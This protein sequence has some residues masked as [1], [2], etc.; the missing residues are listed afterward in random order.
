MWISGTRRRYQD[1][2]VSGA[3]WRIYGLC[4]ALAI[5]RMVF[6]QSRQEDLIN[7]LL[8]QIP[9]DERNEIVTE[10]QIDLSPAN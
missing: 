7:Y 2:A 5:Y 1:A 10:L 4:R 8:A 9:E 3:D 6:G